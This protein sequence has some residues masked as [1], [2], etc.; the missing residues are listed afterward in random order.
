MLKIYLTDLSAY[1]QGF[2]IGE[3]VSLPM[4]GDE[5]KE[6]VSEI[7]KKGSDECGFNEEHEEFFITDY[8]FE[9]TQLFKV[10]EYENLD[11]LNEKCEQL[12]DL[13]EDDQ[14]K[15]S[16]LIDY[17][18]FSFDDALERYEDVS[19]YENTTLEQI[20][21]DFIYE[22]IDMDNIPDII[23]NNIDFKGIAYDFEIS[24][25]YESIE[26]DIFYFLN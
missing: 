11:E 25:E 26:G 15:F 7:L 23:K 16:Y 12:V 14:K 21:E 10:G 8:E 19:I 4:D 17:V 9:G 5:L 24:G 22:T 18:G 3:W 6:K 13:S 20:A 2:L 1:N